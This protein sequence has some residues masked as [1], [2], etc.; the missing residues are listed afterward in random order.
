M[1]SKYGLNIILSVLII[2]LLT[3]TIIFAVLWK[4]KSS[5]SSKTKFAVDNGAI[6]FPPILPDD[7]EYVQWTILHLNDVYEMLP[8]D[9]GKKGV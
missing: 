2:I 9:N 1:K 8:L 3:T 5:S 6:G 4:N 7:S